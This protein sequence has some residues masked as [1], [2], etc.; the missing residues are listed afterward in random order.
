MSQDSCRFLLGAN[1]V[2][3]RSTRVMHKVLSKGHLASWFGA[4]AFVFPNVDFPLNHR[5]WNCQ[6]FRPS[7]RT[8]DP[9][10]QEYDESQW[11]R[12]PHF[13]RMGKWALTFFFLIVRYTC[14]DKHLKVLVQLIKFIALGIM[15]SLFLKSYSL[16]LFYEWKDRQAVYSLF[17]VL[18]LSSALLVRGSRMFTHLARLLRK[19]EC[20]WRPWVWLRGY[21]RFRMIK[22]Q[23][24]TLSRFFLF[25]DLCRCGCWYV[26]VH[27]HVLRAVGALGVKDMAS[28][29]TKYLPSWASR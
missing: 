2:W 4:F 29:K 27:K 13:R 8:R 21:V 16:C 15:F 3:L 5:V 12:V 6:I 14:R 24:L 17:M 22:G 10:L 1:P 19:T 26:C 9:G 28:N 25:A 18:C 11:S 23:T 20:G 7:W